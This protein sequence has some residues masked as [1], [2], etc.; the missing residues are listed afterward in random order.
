MGQAKARGTFA[1]RKAQAIARETALLVD[2]APPTNAV[3]VPPRPCGQENAALAMA[4]A[5]AMGH[6]GLFVIRRNPTR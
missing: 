1:E 3:V 6:G 2:C 4:V 5:A